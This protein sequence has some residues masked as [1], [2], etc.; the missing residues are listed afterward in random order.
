MSLKHTIGFMVAL[1]RL[2]LRHEFIWESIEFNCTRLLHQVDHNKIP[3]I[4]DLFNKNYVKCKPLIQ[5]IVTFLPV[6]IN[7]LKDEDLLNVMKI[8][9]GKNL[10][11]ERLFINFFCKKLEQRAG[12]M[13]KD[14]FIEALKI[15]AKQKYQVK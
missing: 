15:L 13:R 3:V 8:A 14:K 4:V 10:C 5:K 9:L 6:H 7:S 12:K 2:Q 11:S 1:N